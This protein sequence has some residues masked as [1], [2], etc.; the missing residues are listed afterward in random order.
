MPVPR[1]RWYTSAAW[2]PAAVRDTDT[3]TQE[4]HRLTLGPVEKVIVSILILA[5]VGVPVYIWRRAETQ[6]EETRRV[7]AAVDTRTQVMAQQM[8]A[9]SA[10]M[11]DMPAMRVQM[12]RLEVQV[13]RNAQDIAELRAMR[14]L[15]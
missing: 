12:T 8:T 5:V 10:Q 3:R 6:Q 11:A 14:G 15:K 2:R 1:L 7:L 13:G 9:L 4:S